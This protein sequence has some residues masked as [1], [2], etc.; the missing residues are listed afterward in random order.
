MPLV[1][2]KCNIYVE[3]NITF[4]NIYLEYI[5]FG[6]KRWVVNYQKNIYSDVHRSTYSDDHSQHEIITFNLVTSSKTGAKW[7]VDFCAEL[8]FLAKLWAT[9]KPIMSDYVNATV[10][11]TRNVERK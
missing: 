11:D 2:Q 6:Q 8:I 9:T 1:V 4:H 10:T 3:R 5:I 7:R